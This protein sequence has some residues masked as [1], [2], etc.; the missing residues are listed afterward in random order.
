MNDLVRQVETFDQVML[1]LR[2]N[3]ALYVKAIVT[4]DDRDD[5]VVL[6]ARRNL[7]ERVW[8]CKFYSEAGASRDAWRHTKDRHPKI[9]DE[10]AAT[11]DQ[12]LY[13]A[14]HDLPGAEQ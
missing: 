6:R 2:Q 1:V 7:T 11:R 14:G 12:S 10:V 8:N 13:A 3:N 9:I 4:I 5:V